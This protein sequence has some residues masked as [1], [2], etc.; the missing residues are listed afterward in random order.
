MN[1]IEKDNEKKRILIEFVSQNLDELIQDGLGNYSVQH[2]L[3]VINCLERNLFMF[4]SFF[5]FLIGLHPG[6][7]SNLR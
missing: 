4:L 7:Y 2:I 1:R 6:M 5:S 3:E